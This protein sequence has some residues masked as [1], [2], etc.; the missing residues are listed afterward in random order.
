MT[1]PI[2]PSATSFAATSGAGV[3]SRSE[4][5]TEKMRPVSCHGALHRIER[6]GRDDARLVDHHVLAVAHRLDRDCRR[7]RAAPRAQHDDIDRG[8]AHQRVA[9]LDRRHIGEALAK[10]L[11]HARVG[12]LRPV[13]RAGRARRRSGLR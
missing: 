2:A 9:I 10:A 13:A 12:R 1:R 3:I 6:I 4:K 5:Q 8:I 11:E 7:G